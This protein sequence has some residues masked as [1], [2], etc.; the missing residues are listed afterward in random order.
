[1]YGL[2]TQRREQL[3]PVDWLISAWRPPLLRHQHYAWWKIHAWGAAGLF[4][5][6]AWWAS[7]LTLPAFYLGVAYGLHLSIP[8]LVMFIFWGG[9]AMP[10]AFTLSMV[11]AKL[12]LPFADYRWK[13]MARVYGEAF[14]GLA[15]WGG[16][17]FWIG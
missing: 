16:W 14:Y 8:D 7:A 15:L 6:G 11:T 1:M 10:F 3:V 12:S 13:A 2:D 9:A 17:T 5:R 4:L